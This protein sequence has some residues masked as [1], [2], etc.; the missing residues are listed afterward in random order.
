MTEEVASNEVC[1]LSNLHIDEEV[2]FEDKF[3]ESYLVNYAIKHAIEDMSRYYASPEEFT[4]FFGN[5]SLISIWNAFPKHRQTILDSFVI[6][7]RIP[8]NLGKDASSSMMEQYKAIAI[9]V[10][11]TV[12]DS[13]TLSDSRMRV[14]LSDILDIKYDFK[15]ICEHLIESEDPHNSLEY[16]RDVGLNRSDDPE[17]FEF[18][19]FS[20]KRAPGSTEL[21]KQVISHASAKNALSTKIIE[22]IA[23]SSPITLKRSIVKELCG[24]LWD[25]KR[26]INCIDRKRIGKGLS[27][28]EV[29]EMKSS[30]KESV[31]KIQEKLILFAPVVDR[32]VQRNLVENVC[33]ENLVW[34]V[35]AVSQVGN[36]WLSRSLEAAME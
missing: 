33:K 21:K 23:K 2:S 36:S 16:W 3:S 18:A 7:M 9:S 6:P 30:L 31:D 22:A 19:Y 20:I 14:G 34:L 5:G 17:F 27:V 10:H 13:Y 25:L 15:T 26:D 35:P 32:S 8:W 11:D 1:Q 4:S 28:E 12:K 29:E 24:E